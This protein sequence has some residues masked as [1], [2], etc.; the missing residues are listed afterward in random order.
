MV[1][2]AI[3]NQ[4]KFPIAKRLAKNTFN[5][6]NNVMGVVVRRYDNRNVYPKIFSLLHGCGVHGWVFVA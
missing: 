6:V 4:D 3:V 5:G 1:C 2:G